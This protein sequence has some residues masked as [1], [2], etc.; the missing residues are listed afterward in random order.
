MGYITY[1]T[2]TIITTNLINHYALSTTKFVDI[3]LIKR[4]HLI[5]LLS[6]LFG[7]HSP[8]FKWLHTVLSTF[9][10]GAS[11]DFLCTCPCLNYYFPPQNLSSRSYGKKTL[12]LFPNSC[13]SPKDCKWRLLR[14]GSHGSASSI[15]TVSLSF[16]RL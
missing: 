8:L 2:A 13:N 10:I 3:S 9:F 4:S 12:S 15:V 7:I 5:T 6:I 1:F 14:G 16:K 11:N